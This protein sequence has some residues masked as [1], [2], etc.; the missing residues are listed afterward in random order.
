MIEEAW[1]HH[2]RTGEVASCH[3]VAAR[4]VHSEGREHCHTDRLEGRERF[5]T[6]HQVEDSIRLEESYREVVREGHCPKE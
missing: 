6:E 1:V 5:H 3:T 2:L 4:V